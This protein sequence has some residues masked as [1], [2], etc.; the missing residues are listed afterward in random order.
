MMKKQVASYRLMQCFL[1][2][3]HLLA[4]TSKIRF[5]WTILKTTWFW[6]P[7]GPFRHIRRNFWNLSTPGWDLD[8]AHFSVYYGHIKVTITHWK[9]PQHINFWPTTKSCPM[10]QAA[11]HHVCGQIWCLC[12]NSTCFCVILNFWW[13]IGAWQS[14]LLWIFCT[15]L[16]K[17]W[18]CLAPISHQKI[19]NPTKICGIARLTSNLPTNRC[20]AALCIGQDFVVG[21]KLMCWGNFQC[22]MVTLMW[23]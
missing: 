10:H 23:P 13:D 14:Y 15:F 6:P 21:Q 5:R 16:R 19:Q 4:W 11:P 17:R 18:L 9:F 20:G 12:C 8:I 22:I 7:R 2:T 3:T 1:P